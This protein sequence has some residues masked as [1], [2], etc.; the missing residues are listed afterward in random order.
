MLRIIIS[1]SMYIFITS[2]TFLLEKYR[3]I[4][5]NFHF[6]YVKRPFSFLGYLGFYGS[7]LSNFCHF[8]KKNFPKVT[9]HQQKNEL[10]KPNL[11]Y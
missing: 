3:V 5:L 2:V 1:L 4:N 10:M 11:L 9:R 8:G 6:L 7:I